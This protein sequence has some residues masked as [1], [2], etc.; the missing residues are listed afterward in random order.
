MEYNHY[1]AATSADLR[2]GP[3]RLG[4]LYADALAAFYEEAEDLA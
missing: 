3:A 2:D 4:G 1:N